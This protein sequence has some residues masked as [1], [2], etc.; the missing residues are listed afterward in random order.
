MASELKS[1]K[2]LE[3]HKK[4]AEKLHMRKLFD[5]DPKRFEKFSLQF[6]DILVDY[7]KNI[8]TEKTLPLFFVLFNEVGLASWIEKMFNGEKINNTEDRAVLH[9][10]LRNTSNRP[11]LVDGKNITEDVNAVLQKMRKWT[12]DIRSG[13]WVGYTGKRI[14]DIVNIGIGGSDLGPQMV[15]SAL[16]PYGDPNLN[17][18]FVSNI[19]IHSNW[20]D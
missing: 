7:S 6:Q 20:K 1:W 16:K 8:I 9:V 12:E 3:E 14:T 19:G 10:A 13:R 18:H 15:C 2:A 17:V 11:I 4:E 5:E